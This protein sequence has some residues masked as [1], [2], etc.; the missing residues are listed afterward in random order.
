MFSLQGNWGRCWCGGAA[1]PNKVVVEFYHGKQY[2]P[3]GLDTFL[4]K[5]KAKKRTM[6]VMHTCQHCSEWQFKRFTTLLPAGRPQT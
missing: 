5:A 6:A 4:D 3:D 2:L 1:A